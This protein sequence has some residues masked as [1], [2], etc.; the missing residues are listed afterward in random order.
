MKETMVRARWFDVLAVVALSL[1]VLATGP[2]SAEADDK[3]LGTDGKVYLDAAS[4]DAAS[5]QSK[6]DE[7]RAKLDAKL[8][9]WPNQNGFISPTFDGAWRFRV[10]LNGWLPPSVKVTVH[11]RVGTDSDTIGTDFLLGNL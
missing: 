9:P 11:D 2:R 5:K 4:A 10:A 3:A 8:N 7:S 6:A 1:A